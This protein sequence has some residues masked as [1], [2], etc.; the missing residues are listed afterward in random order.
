MKVLGFYKVFSIISVVTLVS[1][2]VFP[3]MEVA[4]ADALVSAADSMSDVTAEAVSN[5]TIKLLLSAT[6]GGIAIGETLTVTFPTGFA[7]GLNGIDFGDVDV[8]HNTTS[9][10][11]C[12]QEAGTE[13]TL[14]ATATGTTWGVAVSTM[15]LTLTAGTETI[16]ASSYI[17]MEIGTNASG[18]DTQIVNPTAGSYTIDIAGTN[19]DVGSAVITTITDS[20]VDVTATVDAADTLTFTINDTAIGFGTLSYLSAKYATADALGSYDSTSAHTLEAES[21][22]TYSITVSGDTLEIGGIDPSIT[23]ITTT[24]GLASSVGSEQFG[25]NIVAAGGSGVVDGDYDGAT[26]YYGGTSS[27]ANEVATCSVTCDTTTTYTAS[28]LANIASST[29]SGSY[30]ATL[31]Y[32]ATGTF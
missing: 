16:D 17:V 21:T 5:H 3:K 2:F 24:G 14:G 11:T 30:S 13:L 18:G 20:S 19:G 9:F 8:C 12:F 25:V 27:L 1:F 31:T 28:Y 7:S 15:T 23:A 6:G 32:V 10:L 4:Y 29:E 26:F 22:G